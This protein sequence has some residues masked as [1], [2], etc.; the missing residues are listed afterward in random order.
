MK[1]MFSQ[2]QSQSGGNATGL[3]AG[4]AMRITTPNPLLPVSGGLGPTA[5]VKGKRGEI[6]VR[7]LYL[8]QGTTGLAFVGIDALGFPAVLGDRIRAKVTRIPGDNILIGATHTH[9]APDYYAFPD[10]KG[11]FS[12]DLKWLDKVC[13]L[14]ARGAES[15]TGCIRVAGIRVAQR[16]R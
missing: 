2:P 8:K 14:A 13:T 15:H 7:V 9:S 5:P 1:S 4:A 10:G 6:G 12:G 3:V 11:G 16:E